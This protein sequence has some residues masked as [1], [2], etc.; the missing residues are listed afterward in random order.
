MK[1]IYYI[2]KSKNELIKDCYIG[3]TNNF[4]KR[5]YTHKSYCINNEAKQLK[6]Y[7][8][9]NQNG[10]WDE[11][12]MYLIEET[13]YETKKECFERERFW[14]EMYEASLNKIK[15]PIRYIEEK[16]DYTNKYNTIY[17]NNNKEYYKNYRENHKEGKKEY[18]KEYYEKKKNKNKI[19]EI[20]SISDE[21][22]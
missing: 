4:K 5:E 22:R 19:V 1:A 16:R 8:F 9:I 10:G 21:L 12:T 18:N 6:L 2:I 17:R 14:I 20:V 3:C 15:K 7:K 13:E 11:W